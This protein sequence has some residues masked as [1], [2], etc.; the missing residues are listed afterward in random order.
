MARDTGCLV[1]PFTGYVT[2]DKLSKKHEIVM[3]EVGSRAMSSGS[4]PISNTNFETMY[5]VLNFSVT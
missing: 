5:K 2:L 3:K 4:D 1:P